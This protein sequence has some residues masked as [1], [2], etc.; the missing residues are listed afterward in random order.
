MTIRATI[1]H[2]KQAGLT[3]DEAMAGLGIIV[4]HDVTWTEVEVIAELRA[5]QMTAPV[6]RLEAA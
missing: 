2:W 3:A 6:E 4:G 5:R 1:A